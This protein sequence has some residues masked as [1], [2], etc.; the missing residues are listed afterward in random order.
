ME[1][2]FAIIG[3]NIRRAR[4]AAHLTQ[5]QVA[6]RI[7][8]STLHYGRIERGERQVSLK[9][10]ARIGTALSTPFES[11][12]AGCILDRENYAAVLENA[13]DQP[14]GYAEYALILLDQYR[15][16]LKAYVRELR[17]GEDALR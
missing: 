3:Q 8:L 5:E 14:A 11:F 10:L 16:Q 17:Q 7:K 13:A 1:I 15:A 6:E 4:K 2:S 12:W 9:Q